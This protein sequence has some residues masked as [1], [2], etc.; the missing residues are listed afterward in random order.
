GWNADRVI[1]HFRP[2][3]AVAA[4]PR[5]LYAGIA[6]RTP[7]A[8]VDCRTL[9]QHN[10]FRFCPADRR[11]AAELVRWLAT[12][13]WPGV[14]VQADDSAH[15]RAL[16]VA[17]SAALA[18]AG[19]QR[20]EELAQA[21]VEVGAGRLNTSRGHWQA[22]RQAGSTRPLVLIGSTGQPQTG[23]GAGASGR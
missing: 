10:G 4:A 14:H 23:T 18:S 11:L 16:C 2:E 7:A 6:R 13:Q 3:P 20:V 21:E 15:G 19:L 1:G 9:E 8:T 22:R 12:R 17:I 5:Y